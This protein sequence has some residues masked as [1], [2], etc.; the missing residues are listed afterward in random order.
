MLL[1]DYSKTFYD[2]YIEKTCKLL[3][4]TENKQSVMLKNIISQFMLNENKI[5]SFDLEYD[6]DREI[7][8]IQI[9]FYI[10]NELIIVFFNPNVTP[11]IYNII[12]PLFIDMN[13]AKIG[14][15]TD[16]MDVP[17]L[18]RLFNDDVKMTA[19]LMRLY[20]TRF[21]CEYIIA[22]TGEKKCNVYHCLETF[23]V[24]DKEQVDFLYDV[25]KKLGKFWLNPINIKSLKEN[26][27]NYAMY[28]VI[29]LKKLLTQL[30]TH[31]R[32]RKLNYNLP[33]QV[34]RLMLLSK[35]A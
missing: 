16:S 33:L 28:D 30:K 35:Q 26:V 11:K 2:K 3:I 14:H 29:Y 4:I 10:D 12:E 23:E 8:L 25:E 18:Y 27:I 32:N 5:L 6:K 31:I 13:V 9:G 34:T 20:D 1:M 7:T 24:V 19:F 17:A 21:L 22:I 15:G